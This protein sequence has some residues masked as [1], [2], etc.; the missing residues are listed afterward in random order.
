MFIGDQCSLGI[1]FY[2]GSM[3]VDIMGYL[4]PQIYFPQI[5]NKV[6]NHLISNQLPTNFHPHK[7][8]TKYIKPVTHEIKS[9]LTSKILIIYEHW[10]PQ[11]KMIS[12]YISRHHTDWGDI[13]VQ[14]AGFIQTEVTLL[15]NQQVF[16]K[17]RRHYCPIRRQ[18]RIYLLYVDWDNSHILCKLSGVSWDRPLIR[19]RHG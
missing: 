7:Y 9:Q 4:Y 6:M 12:Q 13:I 8:L 18:Y 2:R 3:F 17:Q 5:F 16:Y 15:S 11:I 1:N 19:L 10:P 14:S